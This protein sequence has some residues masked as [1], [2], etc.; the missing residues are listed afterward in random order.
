MDRRKCLGLM[1][2]CSQIRVGAGYVQGSDSPLHRFPK[3]RGA[4]IGLYYYT[5]LLLYFLNF[6]FGSE[7][8]GKMQNAHWLLDGEVVWRSLF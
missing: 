6:D 5:L 1:N 8:F 4:N 3:L 2:L 7:I